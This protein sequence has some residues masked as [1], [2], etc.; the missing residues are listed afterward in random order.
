[1]PLQPFERDVKQWLDTADSV[2]HWW[3]TDAEE[4]QSAVRQLL[5][6]ARKLDPEVRTQVFKPEDLLPLI[7]K[8]NTALSVSRP[9][10]SHGLGHATAIW[11]LKSA[12]RV[13]ADHL[14][15][16]RRICLH[17]PELQIRLALFSNTQPVPAVSEG[18]RVRQVV[19]TRHGMNNVHEARSAPLR[20]VPGRMWLAAGVIAAAA[21]VAGVFL[22][23][24]PNAAK[25][26]PLAENLPASESNDKAEL[27]SSSI[28]PSDGASAPATPASE[29]SP[30]MSASRRWLLGLPAD[31]LVVI[32][33]QVATLAEAERFK[34]DQPVL[35]NARILPVDVLGQSPPRY[36][37]VTG[38]F[39]SSDRVYNYVQRLAW[40]ANVSSL[41]R[42]ELLAQVSR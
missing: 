26:A 4:L 15:V 5:T 2:A 1:M 9:G 35:V 42:E 17:Y 23:T 6:L 13:S 28:A 39:R 7:Q 22:P 25:P 41:T 37:V 21:L 31:S 40:K 3:S 33:T 32:H 38:P 20:L 34:A 10:E 12:D 27:L 30:T 8:L 18:V 24:L 14:D 19:H 11:V 36:L 29:T 16:L